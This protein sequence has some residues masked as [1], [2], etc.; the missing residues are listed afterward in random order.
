MPYSAPVFDQHVAALIA[1]MKPASVLDIG[2]GAGKYGRMIKALREGGAEIGSLTAVEI[3]ASY[4]ERFKLGEVYDDIQLADASAMPD[5]DPDGHWDLVIL[6]DV[7]EHFRK[8]RGADLIDYLYYRTKYIIVVVPIDF[9]QGAWEGHHA[10]AHISTWYAS[11]F[12]RYKA[13]TVS[14]AAPEGG[15]VQMVMIN[16]LR[17]DPA[18]DFILARDLPSSG[19]FSAP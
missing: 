5:V 18:S 9:I 3:D 12:S 15:E 7:L 4:V 8:S 17:A 16:G 1:R 6:G 19:I 10:E 13:A 11:D 14:W 2:P